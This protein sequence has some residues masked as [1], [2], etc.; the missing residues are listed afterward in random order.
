MKKM[1]Y[2]GA[3]LMIGASVYGFVD[4][5]KTSKKKEFKAMYVEEKPAPVKTITIDTS[6]VATEKTDL[7]EPAKPVKAQ[8]KT[9]SGVKDVVKKSG[10]RKFRIKEFG[11][12]RIIDEEEK[13]GVG[14][15]LTIDSATVIHK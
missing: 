8:K 14:K 4:F 15:I 1:L 13:V 12:G 7:D 9:E 10:T 6:K 2:A 3:A 5:K 11:R